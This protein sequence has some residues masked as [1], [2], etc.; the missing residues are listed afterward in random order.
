VGNR[1]R[2]RIR[3]RV[4][5]RDRDRRSEAINFGANSDGRSEP[6]TVLLRYGDLLAENCVFFIP[7]SYSASPLHMFPS[8]FRGEV[9][10]QETRAMGLFCG[11][12]CMM[13]TSTEK[14]IISPGR[15]DNRLLYQSGPD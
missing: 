11:E 9:K 12:G 13:L 3:V 5:F 7:L 8:E 4:S 10:R 2:G 14:P 1:V 15:T 6:N